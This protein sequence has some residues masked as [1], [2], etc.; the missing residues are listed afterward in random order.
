MNLI[1]IL[2]DGTHVVHMDSDEYE[3]LQSRKF[4]PPTMAEALEYFEHHGGTESWAEDFHLHFTANGWKTSRVPMKD[5]RAAALRWIK[6]NRNGTFTNRPG[7][8]R[9]GSIVPSDDL[10]GRLAAAKPASGAGGVQEPDLGF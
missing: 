8:H 2:E 10:R 4:K 6:K 7:N 5:W 3:K 1:H 9:N